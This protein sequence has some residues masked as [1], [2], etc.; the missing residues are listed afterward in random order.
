MSVPR[1]VAEI[2]ADHVTLE[3]EGIDRMYLNVYVRATAAGGRRRQFLPL[4]SWSP[5]RFQR[6]DGPDQQD[7]HCRHGSV[8]QARGAFRSCS[9][10][11]GSE[12]TTLLLSI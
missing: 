10:A 5:V 11:K 8:R 4:P 1:S 7:V 12:R 3:V 9:S 2:L 6:A